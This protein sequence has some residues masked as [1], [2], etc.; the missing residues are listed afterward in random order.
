MRR[1]SQEIIPGLFLGPFQASKS[2]ETLQSLNISH[3]YAVTLR[4]LILGRL[5]FRPS[6][7]IRDVDEAFSVKP[8]FPEQFKYLV[9]D[10]RDREEQNI[11]RIFSMYAPLHIIKKG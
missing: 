2:I 3:M 5:T 4:T 7:C 1:Q 9:L 6:L 11:I 10:V 8:R